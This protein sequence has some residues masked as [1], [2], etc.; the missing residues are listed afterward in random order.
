MKKIPSQNKPTAK[1]IDLPLYSHILMKRIE[2]E[3]QTSGT[4]HKPTQHCTEKERK[5]ERAMQTKCVARE[6]NE[7]KNFFKLRAKQKNNTQN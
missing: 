1:S 6:E 3:I 4:E 7:N 2:K 5:R